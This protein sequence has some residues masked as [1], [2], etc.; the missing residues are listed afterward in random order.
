MK[1]FD[2]KG[3]DRDGSARSGLIEA[4]SPKDA[5]EKLAAMGVLAERVEQAGQGPTR[6]LFRRKRT[7]TVDLRATLYRELSSLVGAGLPLVNALEIVIQSPEMGE[8][9]AVIA[10]VR[11]RIKEGSS[12]ADALASVT[13]RIT[14]FEQALIESGEQSGQLDTSLDRVAA[15]LEDQKR[16]REKVSAALIYPAFVFGLAVIIAIGMIVVLLP[17]AVKQLVEARIDLPAIT[18]FAL[19]LSG[20]V[21]SWGLVLA[22]IL[23]L[24]IVYLK[25]RA[26]KDAVIRRR[27]DRRMFRLP[28]LG[29][30][31]TI[32]VNMRFSRTLSLL[33]DAGMPLVES[34][35][36]AGR[37]TGSPW[38]SYLVESEAESVKGGGSLA[39][40]LRRIPQLSG[41]LPGWIQAGEASGDLKKL[42]DKFS[43]RYQ[44]RWDS[45]VAKGLGLLEPIIIMF[46][47]GFVL[48][49]VLSILLPLLSLTRTVG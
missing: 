6:S 22:G 31:Y 14:A 49:V 35:D 8:A 1:T 17:Y 24:L 28:V 33:L 20:F 21:T 19:A 47:G 39:D 13:D 7:F 43:V 29:R 18:R 26:R 3:F 37:A 4:L 36:L 15:F 48:F 34:V 9:R 38:V 27:I 44:R 23:V 41:S 10:G 32:L 25:Q 30:G 2:Y 42:L 11:D 12:M 40:A 16:L 46:V 45:F 5:R